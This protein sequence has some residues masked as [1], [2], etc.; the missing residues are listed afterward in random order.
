MSHILNSPIYEKPWQTRTLLTN[1]FGR[2]TLIQSFWRRECSERLGTRYF[3]HGRCGAQSFGEDC[4]QSLKTQYSYGL[5]QRKLIAPAFST[6]SIKTMTP[7]FFQ[8]A[9]E[10]R[11]KWEVFASSPTATLFED[12]KLPPLHAPPYSPSPSFAEAVIDIAH[13]F[14]LATFDVIG[15]AGFDYHFHALQCESEEVY[16]AYRNMFRIADKGPKLRDLVQLYFPIIE[17]IFV[18]DII[19]LADTS[20]IYCLRCSLMKPRAS[21]TKVSA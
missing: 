20:L 6:Q 7:I 18:S 11:D 21:Q 16:L 9:E 4:T 15:L 19:S 17:N 5:S 10:L 2:G 3:C 13:W 14:S 8:K 12:A 1:L